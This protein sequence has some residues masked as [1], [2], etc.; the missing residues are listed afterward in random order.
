MAS[1]S[2]I[3]CH[4]KDGHVLISSDLY[5]MHHAG[6]ASYT[7]VVARLPSYSV[8]GRS[9]GTIITSGNVVMRFTFRTSG[10]PLVFIKPA[11]GVFYAVLTHKQSGEYWTFDI[12]QSGDSPMVP[13]VLVFTTANA[14]P[15]PTKTNYGI[16]T[17]MANGSTAFDSRLG[18]LGVYGG[19]LAVPPLH[20]AQGGPT[21]D[22]YRYVDMGEGQDS[23]PAL[24]WDF[25][26]EGTHN[27]YTFNGSLDINNM[28]FCAPSLAQSCWVRKIKHHWYDDEYEGIQ[29]HDV[30][31]KWW[32]FYRSAF[33]LR[34]GVGPHYFDA[35]WSPYACG[36]SEK[37]D[38]G[39]SW[40]GGGGDRFN[41]GDPPFVQKTIN[42]FANAFLIGDA[43]NYNV[44]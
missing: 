3:R 8:M 35:G 23:W 22:E 38:Y 20:P 29:N 18:P 1:Q 32:V 33:R 2:G 27:T 9:G 36:Y 34:W 28:M 25:R 7:G 43:S 17:Y 19:G 31:R 11:L 21:P 42:H 10:V 30:E 37:L 12:I 40:F 14:L 44:T 16:T 4:N 24:D 6:D 13:R 39:D 26:S 15:K 5:G 41:S